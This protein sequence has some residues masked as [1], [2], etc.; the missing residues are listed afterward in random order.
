MNIGGTAF[1]SITGNATLQCDFDHL[2]SAEAPVKSGA[3]LTECHRTT[4]LW[5]IIAESSK[6]D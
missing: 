4:L 5:H 2:K 1:R 6:T 3:A